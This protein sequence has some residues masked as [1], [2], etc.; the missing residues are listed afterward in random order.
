MR[1]RGE[2]EDASVSAKTPH[3]PE[4]AEKTLEM[5]PPKASSLTTNQPSKNSDRRTSRETRRSTTNDQRSP[6]PHNA[7]HMATSEKIPLSSNGQS[8]EA[9]EAATSHTRHSRGHMRSPWR[10]SI[11][12]LATSLCSIILLFTIVHSFLTRQQD[13][14]GCAMS[15][16]RPAFTRFSDFDTEHTRFA[17]KYSLYLYREAGVDEDTRVK[18]V[19][20]LFIPGNAGSYKQM[21]PIAAE[22]ANYFQDVLREDGSAEHGGKRP[23]DF[24]TVDFNEELTAFHGQTL[25]DQA[26]YLNEAV[27]YILALY[28]NPQ[29]SVRESGLPDPKSVIIV[30]HSM[31]GV[32]A[33]TMLRMQNYQESSINTIITLSAP[34][35][36][37]PV[38]FDADMVAAY[39]NDNEYWRQSFS[40]PSIEQ[41]PLSDITL[42]SVAGGGLDTMIPSE[43]SSL[44]SIVPDTHGFTVFTSSIPNVWTGMD[45]LAI[46]WCN[47]FRR[48]LV[49]A[50]FDVVDARRPSQTTPQHERIT[51]LRK[52]LLTGMESVVQKAAL[53]QGT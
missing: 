15:Y 37:P 4:R 41:N 19:P 5:T 17:S 7:D 53:D 35:A 52:R 1:R 9:A 6:W 23:L 24:F 36:R 14:K 44:T 34:H 21:R 50:I 16:M 42:V 43:Y 48:A 33:R 26:E 31:G 29:R 3:P 46:M 22:A 10:C 20:A 18:G 13:P 47:Q 25:L 8:K 38:S 2:D 45:H 51:A 27:R 32:V 12:T 11:L 30:G 28:H 40:T 39:N 49:R